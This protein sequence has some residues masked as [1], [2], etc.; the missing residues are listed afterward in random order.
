MSRA[1]FASRAFCLSAGPTLLLMMLLVMRVAN[2]KEIPHYVIATDGTVTVQTASQVAARLADP[3]PQARL[4]AAW[5]LQHVAQPDSGDV[6]LPL[7]QL[8]DDPV[9]AVRNQASYTLSYLGPNAVPA[10]LDVIRGQ[11]MASG[12]YDTSVRLQR[13]A[14]ETLGSLAWKSEEVKQALLD[15]VQ[16][17]RIHTVVRYSA[18]SGLGRLGTNAPGVAPVL[19][20]LLRRKNEDPSLRQAAI[21]TLEKLRPEPPPVEALGEAL[22]DPD[23]FVRR[24]AA[25]VLGRFGPAAKAALPQLQAALLDADSEVRLGAAAAIKELTGTDH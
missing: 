18:F 13:L 11:G 5:L 16:D 8:L 2:A 12:R 25:A 7:V 23:V 15:I 17:P 22:R 10:L 1:R 4:S 14:V 3:D 6:I 19:V 21:F 20:D 24:T 9:E